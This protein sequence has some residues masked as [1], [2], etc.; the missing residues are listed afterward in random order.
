MLVLSRKINQQICIGPDIV[1]T[2]VDVRGDR[3]RLGIEAPKDVLVNR[4][5]VQD[6]VDANGRAAVEPQQLAIAS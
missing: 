3:V 5:E 6:R 2:I 1:I 4:R